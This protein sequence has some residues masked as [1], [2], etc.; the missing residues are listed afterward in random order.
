MRIKEKG[1]SMPSGDAAA[2]TVCTGLYFY[3][4]QFPWYMLICVPLASLGRVYVHCHWIGD[5]IVGF[6]IGFIIIQLAYDT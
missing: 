6:V 1:K 5:T 4:F 3:V 2:A